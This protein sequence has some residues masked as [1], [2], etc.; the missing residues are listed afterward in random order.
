[1][2]PIFIPRD[3][4]IEHREIHWKPLP[5]KNGIMSPEISKPFIKS[6]NPRRL[7][8]RSDLYWGNCQ[9]GPV[10]PISSRVAGTSWKYSL[11]RASQ[12]SSRRL[13]KNF[14]EKSLNKSFRGIIPS[15]VAGIKLRPIPYMLFRPEE[16]HGASGVRPVFHPFSQRDCNI[17]YYFRRFDFHEIPIRHFH[18]H[19]IAAI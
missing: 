15:A 4:N 6:R 19:R 2:G 7:R 12:S 17:T 16:I 11:L 3:L 14:P 5:Q 8:V 10:F 1:M 18:S 13:R 9:N